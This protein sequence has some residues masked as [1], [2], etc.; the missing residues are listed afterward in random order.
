MFLRGSGLLR[1]I[2][3]FC[4]WC[5]IAGYVGDCNLTFIYSLSLFTVTIKFSVVVFLS[6]L[7]CILHWCLC[8]GAVRVFLCLVR[9]VPFRLICV[10]FGG[11][12]GFGGFCYFLFRLLFCSCRS[13]IFRCRGFS[14]MV[15]RTIGIW[16]LGI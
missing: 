8:V 14:C 2:C 13:S 3:W 9:I 1:C 6:L 16:L 5:S 4:K 7:L 15:F 12:I 11:T 10:C